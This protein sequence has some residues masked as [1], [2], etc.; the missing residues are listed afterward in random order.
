VTPFGLESWLASKEHGRTFR[1]NET[2]KTRSASA[3]ISIAHATGSNGSSTKLS[4]VGVLR[5]DTPNSRPTIWRSSNSH[6]S[7]FGYA[8]MSAVS[9]RASSYLQWAS[10]GTRTTGE[11]FIRNRQGSF[12]R[13]KDAKAFECLNTTR[14][15]Q[16]R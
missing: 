16:V 11:V 7:E 4:N 6:Q 1:R 14:V 3:P 5:P 15:K 13:P 8:V 10:L 9:H 12:L 2:A